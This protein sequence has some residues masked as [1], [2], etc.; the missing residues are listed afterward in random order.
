MSND[1]KMA[2]ELQIKGQAIMFLYNAV[3]LID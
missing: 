1:I 2:F 3:L